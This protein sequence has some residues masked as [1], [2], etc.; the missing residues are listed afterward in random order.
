VNAFNNSAGLS[1][2]VFFFN[3]SNLSRTEVYLYVAWGLLLSYVLGEL[4]LRSVPDF[5]IS[6][7]ALNFIILFAW[8]VSVKKL[9]RD[10][11]SPDAS[12][13]DVIFGLSLL[14]IYAVFTIIW[15]KFFIGFTIFVL[16]CYIF[17]KTKP[18]EHSR[19]AS[20]VLF[21]ISGNTFF[22]PI[23]YQLT[24]PELIHADAFLLGNLLKIIRPDIL[25]SGAVF[26]SADGMGIALVGACSSFQ[27][28]SLAFVAY[29]AIAI[30]TRNFLVRKDIVF[31]LI[32][33]LLMIA[34]NDIRLILTTWNK[35]YYLY[36]HDGNGA[37]IYQNI[38][39]L[40]IVITAVW[41]VKIA[42]PKE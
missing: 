23:F 12:T 34:L 20:I 42:A 35:A 2:R 5:K 4:D 37:V 11:A 10:K 7:S 22:S 36:W 33:G 32:I 19:A 18:G 26:K 13:T 9:L 30:Y 3:K 17:R 38:A 41:G 40:V 8:F 27:N 6:L 24:L 31:I 29:I 14:L 21:A 39:N 15:S 28:I 25:W 16:A 1:R